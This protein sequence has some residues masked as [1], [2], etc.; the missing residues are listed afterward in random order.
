MKAASG[1]KLNPKLDGFAQTSR[2]DVPADGLY[3][4]PKVEV[5]FSDKKGH[6][7]RCPFSSE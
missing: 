2:G 7:G 3:R 6:L 1:E 5:Y 4:D